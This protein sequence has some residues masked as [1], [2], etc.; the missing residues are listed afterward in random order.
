MKKESRVL[1]D[2][3]KKLINLTVFSGD[4]L[5]KI[6]VN[7]L[8]SGIFIFDYLTGGGIPESR[9]TCF[10]GLKAS[11]KTTTALRIASCYL[12]DNP[13][14][15]VLFAD[16]EQSYDDTFG[17]NFITNDIKDRFFVYIPS[18]A[19]E[20]IDVIKSSAEMDDCGLIIVDS[21][22]MMIP[23][24]ESDDESM[25]E[26]PGIQ[27]K[28][29]SKLIRKLVPIIAQ[30]REAGKAL[31]VLFINQLRVNFKSKSFSVSYVK[32]GGMLQEFIFSLDVRFYTKNKENDNNDRLLTTFSIEKSRIGGNKETAEFVTNVRNG[33]K[34]ED[35][36]IV[37]KLLKKRGLLQRVGNTWKYS[38]N[39]FKTLEEVERFFNESDS[40]LS[41]AKEV[42]LNDRKMSN[43]SYHI[44]E[45]YE[46]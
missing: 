9:I 10:H 32:P 41:K 30:K 26:H 15:S 18:Y 42:L 1:K 2:N 34:I 5:S 27:A 36:D 38:E 20:G 3:L 33:W 23:I 17:S 31:T 21:I 19:E 11:G 12:K 37:I 25:Q 35:T 8:K 46:S 45:E 28:A 29:V 39:V 13:N 40:E 7:R 44:S 43:V 22:A 4:G 6:L 16:F 24:K 14:M